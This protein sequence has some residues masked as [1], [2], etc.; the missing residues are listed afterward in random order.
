MGEDLE[1]ITSEKAARFMARQRDKEKVSW[2]TVYPRYLKEPGPPTCH[3]AFDLLDKMLK[4]DPRQR[5]SVDDALCHPYMATLH[6]ED[7]EPLADKPFKFEFKQ[8]DLTKR[9]LQELMYEQ[10]LA[11]HPLDP[12]T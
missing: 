11:Y 3:E 12:S 2:A 10:S 5:I 8:S 4:F 9:R 1:F 7:D 6:H